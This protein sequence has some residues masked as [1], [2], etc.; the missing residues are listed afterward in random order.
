MHFPKEKLMS[1]FYPGQNCLTLTFW[2]LLDTDKQTDRKAKFIYREQKWRLKGTY[3]L[4]VA[5]T[6][7]DVQQD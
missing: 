2:R 3:W 6:Y 4:D 7:D 1:T 5:L